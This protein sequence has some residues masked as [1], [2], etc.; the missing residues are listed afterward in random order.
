MVLSGII[1]V[2]TGLVGNIVT[3]I[4]NLKVQKLKNVHEEKLIELETQAMLAKTD[5]DI[6]ITEAKVKGKL[7]QI[8]S[9]TYKENIKVGN[10]GLLEK[11]TI[12]K[13]FEGKWTKWLGVLL[14]FMLGIVD[15]LKGFI[16][17]ILTLYLVGLTSWLTYYAAGILSSK[18]ALLGAS[19]ASIIFRNVTEIVIYL[20]VSVVT[21]WFADRRVAK[22]LGRLNDGNIKKL[23]DVRK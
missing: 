4:T 17:P 10:K 18:E 6:R 23:N 13:L 1:G 8:E 15:V 7:D 19:E 12:A 21:W 14:T 3:S 2:V 5:A 9:E 20:T 16:R 22:F 11:G